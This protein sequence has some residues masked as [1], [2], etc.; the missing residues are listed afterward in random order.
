MLGIPAGRGGRDAGPED[1]RR[2]RGKDRGRD[3]RRPQ[4]EPRTEA[5]RTG[6]GVKDRESAPRPAEPSLAEAPAQERAKE[7]AAAQGQDRH[8]GKRERERRREKERKPQGPLVV[9]KRAS[10][11][12]ETRPLDAAPAPVSTPAPAPEAPPL[13]QSAEAAVGTA[14]S[15][16]TPQEEA[17]SPAEISALCEEVPEAQSFAEMLEQSVKQDGPARRHFRVGERV[18]GKIFQL[19]AETAFVSLG[20]SEAMIDLGELKDE[21]GILRYGVGDAVDA[22]VAEAG[23]KGV[24]LSKKVSSSAASLSML[25][26]ARATGIPVEGLVLSVNKG[27]LE[28]AVGEVRAFCPASQVD[29]RF[30]GKLDQFVGEKHLFRVMEVRER[31]VVLSR[32]AVLE[33][34]QRALAAQTRKQ[35]GEGKV[36]KGKVTGVR[37][38]GAFV[39]LGGIEGLIPVSELSHSRVGHPNEVVKVGDEVEVEVLKIEPPNPASSD[40]AKHKERITLSMRARQEDPWKAVLEEV[41][42]GVRVKGKVVRLQPFGAFVELRPGVDG[43]IHVSAL[44]SRR[45]AHP[46]DVVQVGPEVTVQVEKVDAAERRIGLRLVADGEAAVVAEVP[47]ERKEAR[48]RVGQVVT[49]TIDRIEPY[50]VFVAFPG[51]KGLVPASE[52]GM[53]RGTDMKRAYALGQELTAQIVEIDGSGKIRLSVTSAQREAERVEMDAW[54]RSQPKGGGGKG[55]G[56]LGD[57]L[58]GRKQ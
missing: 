38:F 45:V 8:K 26:E 56:T 53:E 41:K 39:D 34:E 51:G 29:V 52:T 36:L 37:E 43:L 28:V 25:S 11:A 16:A 17:K 48:P 54:Q 47:K 23:A 40:K 24:V 13:G 22:Y 20:K 27:G 4:G 31:K 18:T 10:G 33:E 3:E 9:V 50:G 2:D 55:F 46:K 32:R 57:L 42:E 30:Q 5:Q 12:V 15:Q 1:R 49:G 7:P 19:G 35:L 44:S 58:K 14:E 21:E 6:A